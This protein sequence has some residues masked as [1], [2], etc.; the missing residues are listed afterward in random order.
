MASMIRV[1]DPNEHHCK[2]NR[3]NVYVGCDGEGQWFLETS[4]VAVQIIYCPWCAKRLGKSSGGGK[5]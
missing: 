1:E 4:K 3:N 2:N 5:D